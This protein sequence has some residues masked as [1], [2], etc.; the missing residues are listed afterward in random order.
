MTTN[1]YITQKSQFLLTSLLF[2]VPVTPKLIFSLLKVRYK[3]IVLVKKF[4]LLVKTQ[5]F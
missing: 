4:L 2:K 1:D 5:K 3:Y